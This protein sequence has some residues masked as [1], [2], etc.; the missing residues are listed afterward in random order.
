MKS[1]AKLIVQYL[2]LR[3]VAELRWDDSSKIIRVEPPEISTMSTTEDASFT[4]YNNS[5]KSENIISYTVPMEID[6]ILRVQRGELREAA[7]LRWDGAREL[8]IGEQPERATMT[9]EN[10]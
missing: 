2:Q 10:V 3:E 1:D 7:Q 6:A 5:V 8:I 9:N 4:D